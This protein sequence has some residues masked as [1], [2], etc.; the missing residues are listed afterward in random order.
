MEFIEFLNSLFTI[1]FRRNIRL[2][3]ASI[4]NTIRVWDPKDMQC[5]NILE[6]AD[7]DE[8]TCLA[9]LKFSNLFVTGHAAG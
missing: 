7:K 5:Q 3:S 4:D 1:F 9:Y 6:N 8:I 2:I